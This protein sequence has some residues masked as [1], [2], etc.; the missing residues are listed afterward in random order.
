ML[1]G[2]IEE[3]TGFDSR[4]VSKTIEDFIDAGYIK[5]RRRGDNLAWH[6]THN[7]RVDVN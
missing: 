4:L 5:P 2:K 6:W 1:C 3:A 7:N